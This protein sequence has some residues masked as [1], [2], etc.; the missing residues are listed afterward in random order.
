MSEGVAAARD[1]LA[2]RPD[3]AGRYPTHAERLAWFLELSEIGLNTKLKLAKI[4][5]QAAAAA[6][7]LPG[8]M[9][10]ILQGG[11]AGNLARE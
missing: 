9:Q 4:E 10:L 1:V 11:P 5:A 6:V 7:Q 2:G 3:A 8:G